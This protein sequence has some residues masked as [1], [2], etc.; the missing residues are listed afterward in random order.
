M[1]MA[2]RSCEARPSRQWLWAANV[3]VE[4]VK[5][6][7]RQLSRTA[8]VNSLEHLQNFKAVVI[9]PVKFGPNQRAGAA[10]SYIFGVDVNKKQ[11]ARVTA[12]IVPKRKN[13]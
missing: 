6:S 13:E 1:Q 9:R 5:N 10:G 11:Y 8:L 3:F 4:T 7:D 12:R 2:G